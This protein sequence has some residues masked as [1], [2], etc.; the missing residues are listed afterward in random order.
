M[1]NLVSL[2][3]SDVKVDMFTLF[4]LDFI[5][6]YTDNDPELFTASGPGQTDSFPKPLFLVIK[7]TRNVMN[8]VWQAPKETKR[9][10][11]SCAELPE[12]VIQSETHLQRSRSAG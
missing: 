6:K 12:P 3:K 10:I 7:V 1:V 9:C 2:V 4:A 5:D 8:V 11:L